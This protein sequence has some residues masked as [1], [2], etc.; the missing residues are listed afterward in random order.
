MAANMYMEISDIDG[1]AT[2]KSFENWLVLE[3]MNWSLTRSVDVTDGA[4]TQRGHANTEF[5]KVE[6]TS[7]LGKASNDI[8]T[9][10]A[11]G[12]PRDSIK[13][14]S[15]RSGEGKSTGQEGY[16]IWTLYDVVIDAYAISYSGG[17]LPEETW[18]LSFTRIAHEFKS[19]DQKTMKLTKASEF[20]WDVQK[21]EIG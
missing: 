19:T 17:D 6:V 16:S 3:S 15:T 13:I 5:G 14:V 8:M 10:V 2:T 4:S 18:S 1:D 20:L 9:N 21:G 12:R 7:K 11:N